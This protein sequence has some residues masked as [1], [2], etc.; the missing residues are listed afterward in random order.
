M[1]LVVNEIFNSI[2]GESLYA[3]L[4]CTFIRLAGC[5]LRCSYCDTRYAY[6]EGIS[7]TMTDILDKISGYECPLVEITGGEP[8]IQNETPL[9]ITNLIENGYKVL[10]ETNGTI[11]ISGVDERCVKIVDIK[12][13][14]SGES[15]K[16]ILVN[17][18]SLN[19]KDQ[20]KFVITN[21]EDYEYAKDII[22]QI[23]GR[24]L[25]EN[26]LISPVP[27]KMAFSGLANR[28]LEDKLMVRF[29]IQLHKIIWPDINRGV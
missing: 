9:L 6:E 23:P 29:H 26:I 3:G 28:I 2:Q 14:G 11:D 16:N 15:G 20:I 7:L 18:N 12:C 10:L 5:N 8:L 19:A 24:F 27:G 25:K 22:K 17:L 13:P 4:R 21:L 1:S